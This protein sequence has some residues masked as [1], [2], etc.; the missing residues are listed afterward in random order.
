MIKSYRGLLEDGDQL[1]IHLGTPDGKTGY[2]VHKFQILP[3]EADT[4]T[5]AAVKIYKTKQATVTDQINFSDS[6]LLAA[7]IMAET[8]DRSIYPG[9]VIFDTEIFNQDIYI[10]SKGESFTPNMNFYLE[11]EQVKLTEVEALV[12]IVKNLRTEQ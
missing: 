5:E 10:T 2:R 3:P 6:S 11:L 9:V 4:N 12:A 7:A 1:K 8:T